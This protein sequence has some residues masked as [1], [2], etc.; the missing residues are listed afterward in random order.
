MRLSS[1][2]TIFFVNFCLFGVLYI[3]YCILL[4]YFDIGMLVVC[5]D[6]GSSVGRSVQLLCQM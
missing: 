6:I 5:V 2:I 4:C 3:I 1:K